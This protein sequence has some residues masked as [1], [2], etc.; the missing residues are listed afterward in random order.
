VSVPAPQSVTC[1]ED[2]G[3]ISLGWTNSAVYDAVEVR[4]DGLPVATLAGSATSYFHTPNATGTSCAVICGIIG[5][6]IGCSTEC[7]VAW[8]GLFEAAATYTESDDCN[9]M[10]LGDLNGDQL[11]DLVVPH[12]TNDE[13]IVMLGDADGVLQ[14]GVSYPAGN[15]CQSVA[16]G[17]LDGDAHLDLVVS[18]GRRI[19][20]LLGDGAGGLGTPLEYSF[21]GSVIDLV[22]LYDFD[23]D[24]NL[25]VVAL[26][27]ERTDIL[28]LLGNGDGTF[29]PDVDYETGDEPND[30]AVGDLDN[31]GALDIVVANGM[32]DDLSVFLGN[33]DGSFQTPFLH[34]VG[35]NPESVALGDLDEDGILDLAVV[36]NDDLDVSIL[37]G[38]GDGT[39]LWLADYPTGIAPYET[40][41]ADLDG[42]D[43]LDLAVVN[44]FGDD[45][46]V[47]LGPGD[48]SLGSAVDYAVGD[49]PRPVTA[50]D[51]GND[52][53]VDLVVCDR[54][55]D[56][57]SVLINRTASAAGTL[58]A[59]MD[60]VPSTGTLPFTTQ[61]TA[62]L[63]NNYTGQIRRLAA[64][65]NV[66]IA[67][68][69]SFSNWR[70][71]YTNVA[72]GDAYV[73]AWNQ[74]LPALGT[75]VGDNR[76]D[77]VAEDITPA[78][79]NQ[80]PYPPAGDTDTDSCMVTGVAP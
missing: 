37:Q 26:D 57:I 80:P 74:N 15:G 2:P 41:L 63:T 31:D 54:G 79:Y 67:G 76:F 75:L 68:G 23:G 14:P 59:T 7:C 18:G 3:G 71:G 30:F 19:C 46:S 10:A 55:V 1:S 17:L 29:Q 8:L 70:G 35:Q 38:N 20:V 24:G 73:S 69:A 5:S 61:M 53:D 28:I 39:F 51:L 44:S 34:A 42:D 11:N 40:I 52:G 60:C 66:T 25:D 78:P 33:G 13:V 12:R 6:D 45:V 21:T 47:Y 4:V 48:G 77:L 36:N 56:T 43:H 58:S 72:A 50:G 65:I 27:V 49:G 32:D 62:T 64:R 22:S 9:S 16:L